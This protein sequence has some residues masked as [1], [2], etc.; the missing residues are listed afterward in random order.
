MRKIAIIIVSLIL[1]MALGLGGCGPPETVIAPPAETTP[2]AP[3]PEKVQV[4]KDLAYVRAHGQNY[5]DDAD[6]EPEGIEIFVLYF[7]KNSKPMSF[8]GVTVQIGIE[9]YAYPLGPGETFPA[10]DAKEELVY[11]E[12][13]TRDHTE[14]TTGGTMM[15]IRIPFEDVIINPSEWWEPAFHEVTIETPSGRIFKAETGGTARLYP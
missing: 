2:P 9:L 3:P 14:Q 5:T 7:D 10:D 6:P 12:R 11:E 1:A 8:E 15:V 13:L 4:I